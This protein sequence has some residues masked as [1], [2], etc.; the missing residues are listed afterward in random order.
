MTTSNILTVWLRG[1][2]LAELE[3][4][5]TGRLRLRFSQAAVNTYGINSRPLSLSLPITTKRVESPSL[6]RYLDNLLPESGLRGALERQHGIRPGDTFGL[7]SRIGQ[8]C[9]GA[10]QFTA[11]GVPPGAGHL[12]QLTAKEVAGIVRDLPT[13][14]T[15]DNLPVSALL[16]GV[17]AKVML[18]RTAGGW[19]LA[20]G[21]RYIHAPHQA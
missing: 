7:L 14:V 13:I 21:R 3:R 19:A 8:E 20:H 15:P 9:A 6:E 5:R 17:Q 4:L 16:G 12:R 2:E 1:Q 11:A 18:A 10:V